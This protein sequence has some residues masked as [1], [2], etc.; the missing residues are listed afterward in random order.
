MIF[1]FVGA[2]AV[3]AVGVVI[4]AAIMFARWFDSLPESSYADTLEGKRGIAFGRGKNLTA[5][6]EEGS[7][8]LHRCRG[9][10]EAS[11]CHS[12]GVHFVQGCMSAAT[13]APGECSGIPKSSEA[14][15]SMNWRSALCKE[16]YGWSKKATACDEAAHFLQLRCEKR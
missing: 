7:Y 13:P 9:K 2:V 10:A 4:V 12:A 6:L 8:E 14:F 5:C 16:K 11:S 1:G 15:H 3:L